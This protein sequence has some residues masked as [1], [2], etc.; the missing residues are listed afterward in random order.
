MHS[1]PLNRVPSAYLA[2]L[3]LAASCFQAIPTRSD[4]WSLS[5]EMAGSQPLGM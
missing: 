1:E 3:R 2:Y 4:R 5:R